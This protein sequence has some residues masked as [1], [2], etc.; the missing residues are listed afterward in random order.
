MSAEA[1]ICDLADMKCIPCRGGVPPMERAKAEEM[2]GDLAEG[3]RL[4][5]Q[6]HLERSFAFK[7]FLEAMAFANKV[8]DIAEEEGHHPDLY[9]AWG[10]VGIEIW[11]HKIS[12]LTES[13]FYLAAKADRAFG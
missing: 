3:W 5:D 9:V 13:D 12:G 8:G 7:N 10:K 1:E 11:T 4:N 6:G 2:L